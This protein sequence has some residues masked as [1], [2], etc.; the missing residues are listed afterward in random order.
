MDLF[1]TLTVILTAATVILTIAWIVLAIKNNNLQ[2]DVVK[3]QKEAG[4]LQ[5]ANLELQRVYV[6]LQKRFVELE[7]AREKESKKLENTADL[8]LDFKS[9][10]GSGSGLLV[11][12]NRG[13]ATASN[14]RYYIN[15][16]PFEVLV[17]V[18]NKVNKYGMGPW[19]FIAPDSS[20]QW[21]ICDIPEV[22]GLTNI[23]VMGRVP[24]LVE[25]RVEKD[26]ALS[27]LGA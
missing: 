23:K 20:C 26:T 12:K 19:D 3:L 1:Q 21:H 10:S 25:I 7:E 8:I 17:L 24:E 15:D 9:Y 5:K 16:T 14:V 22:S 27:Y 4:D 2:K 11:V 18:E 13:R 6:E